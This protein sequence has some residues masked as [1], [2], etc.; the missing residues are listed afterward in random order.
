MRCLRPAARALAPL[1]PLVLAVACRQKEDSNLIRLNGR[2]EAPAVDLAPKV[3]GRVTEVR[4]REG[5]HVKAGDL[6]VRLDLGE[7]AL[8][9][10][11]DVEGV[12][13]AEARVNDLAAGNRRPEI[14]AAEADVND[15]RAAV[16]LARKEFERQDSLLLK[17]VGSQQD[18]DVARTNVE[19][20]S[21]ALKASQDRLELM[22][23]GFRTFQKEQ[24]RADLERAR[25]VLTQSQT[26]AK[27]GE[28]RAPAD[29]IVLH[30]IAEPGLLVGPGQPALTLAFANRLY[31]RTFIPETKLGKVRP[32]VAASVTVDA[33]PG[34]RFPAR[35]T[36]VSPDSEFTP[37]PVDT[38]E[39]R[40]NL[41]YGAKVDLDAGWNVPLFPGQPAQ[42]TV[43]IAP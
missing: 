17:K 19:R 22:R 6:L 12:K 42:V 28:I 2:L 13:S 35:V 8:A 40:V 32:G 14:A 39:E 9:V 5:D 43:R 34:R 1:L 4:V 15:K 27:E 30:R 29:G 10:A 33:Y 25:S 31:V 20:A 38:R 36:E 41:V 7:T 24:A 23:E 3:A 16:T 37:K 26:V 21:A 11:R 18:A